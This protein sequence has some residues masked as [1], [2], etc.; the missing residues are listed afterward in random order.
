MHV[1]LDLETAGLRPNALILT[2]GMVWFDPTKSDVE[3]NEA[4]RLYIPLDFEALRE[5]GGFTEDASTAEWWSEQSDKAFEAAWKGPRSNIYLSAGNVLGFLMRHKCEGVWG[6]GAAFDNALMRHFFSQVKN[7]M[8]ETGNTPRLPV[9]WNSYKLD[10]C[11]RTLR[12]MFDDKFTGYALPPF[13]GV[14]HNA[15]DDAIYQAKCAQIMMK[16]LGIFV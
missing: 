2:I 3:Q 16:K 12:A 1:M 15:L 9:E 14:E 7:H 13:E 11:Y 8:I 4:D 5:I 6:N 10:R